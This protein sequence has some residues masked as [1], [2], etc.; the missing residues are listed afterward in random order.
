[1]H[2]KTLV[3]HLLNQQRYPVLSNYVILDI[4][5]KSIDP[6][7][8]ESTVQMYDRYESDPRVVYEKEND[9]FQLVYLSGERGRY[10]FVHKIKQLDTSLYETRC[11]KIKLSRH[12]INERLKLHC[13]T[14]E[15]EINRFLS[16]LNTDISKIREFLNLTFIESTRFLPQYIQMWVVEYKVRVI[17]KAACVF[18]DDVDPKWRLFK[19]RLSTGVS[20]DCLI[21]TSQPTLYYSTIWKTK[22]PLAYNPL[23]NPLVVNE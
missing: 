9:P 17:P 14:F 12:F 11:T 10:Y 18:G 1:M 20:K 16:Y 5:Y 19:N 13:T 8:T 4:Y 7:V 2:Y 6:Q 21:S 15:E 23:E 3:L 22:I